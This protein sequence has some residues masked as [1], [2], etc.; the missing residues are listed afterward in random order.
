MATPRTADDRAFGQRPG[1]VTSFYAPPPVPDDGIITLP[2]DEASHA[3]TVCRLKPKDA[4]T[5][6][7]GEGLA[8]FCTVVTATPKKFAAQVIKTVKNWGE[9]QVAVTLAA[10]LS[11]GG[12][13]D[14]MCEKATELGATRIIPFISEKSAVKIDETAAAN[15]KIARYRRI[16]LAAMKQSLRSIWPEVGPICT[17]DELIATFDAYHRILVGDPTPGSITFDKTAELVS[18][19]RKI[20]LIVGPESGFSP[21]EIDRLRA[22]GAVSTALGPRRLRTETAAIAFLARIMGVF[23][24]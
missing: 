6:V 12:K 15:R 2:P 9:P 14:W 23:E 3:H 5:I 16:T 22:N 19:A 8:H 17:L 18:S 1:E 4:I 7:D 10:G 13:F 21:R 11:K 24:P 20:L